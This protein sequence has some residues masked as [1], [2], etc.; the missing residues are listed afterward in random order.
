MSYVLVYILG[1]LAVENLATLLSTVDLL[2]RP[3]KWLNNKSPVAGK[4]ASCR[5]CQSFWLSLAFSL[6]YPMGPFV[7]F[8]GERYGAIAG[9]LLVWLSAHGLAVMWAEFR[10][11]YLNRAPDTKFVRAVVKMEHES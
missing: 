1:V 11:R 6:A 5:L 3:R 7:D 8:F 10:D 2:D 4:L 9:T